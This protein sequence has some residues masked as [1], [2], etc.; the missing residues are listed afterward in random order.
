MPHPDT[1]LAQTQSDKHLVLAGRAT[2]DDDYQR[3]LLAQADG[4]NTVHFTGFVRG[5]LLQELYTNAYLVVLP[6]ELEGLSVSLLEALG[7]GNCLLVSDVPEN[8]EAVGDAGHNFQNGDSDALAWQM[9]WLLD[10][11]DQIKAA[12]ARAQAWATGRMDWQQVAK[13]TEKLYQSL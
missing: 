9:Q 3:R 13:A 4:L 11:P 7:Y 5:E 8:L 12:R 10:R 1:S 2:Y 6:S